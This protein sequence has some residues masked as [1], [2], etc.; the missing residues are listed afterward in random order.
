MDGQRGARKRETAD[1]QMEKGEK[2]IDNYLKL[3]TDASYH[4]ILLK[5]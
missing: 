1:V 5:L 2:V 3:F 4:F